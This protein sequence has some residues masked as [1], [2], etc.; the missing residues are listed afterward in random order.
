MHPETSTMC[1]AR[2]IHLLSLSSILSQGIIIHA[3]AGSS[4][5]STPAPFP[6]Q[7]VPHKRGWTSL[8]HQL[9]HSTHH[10]EI[11]T[12][13][14]LLNLHRPTSIP[15]F[16]AIHEQFFTFYDN[17]MQRFRR[18]TLEPVQ[19][20]SN[21]LLKRGKRDESNLLI[22]RPNHHPLKMI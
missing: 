17:F 2:K 12:C 21:E 20:T 15:P 19:E 9:I 14:T 4:L 22:F 7:Q 18:E 11:F 10:L 6:P 5:H 1:N 16:T 8:Y 13:T 3:S